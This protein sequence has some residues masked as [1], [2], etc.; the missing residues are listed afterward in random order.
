MLSR[1]DKLLCDCGAISSCFLQFWWPFW[2]GAIKVTSEEIEV[3]DILIFGGHRC[4]G[5]YPKVVEVRIIA[6]ML[7]HVVE[8]EPFLILKTKKVVLFVKIT[9]LGVGL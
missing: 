9:W 5:L 8:F 4:P 7:E 1:V 2:D 3:G 6:D